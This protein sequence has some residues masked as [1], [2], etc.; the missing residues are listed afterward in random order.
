MAQVVT[1]EN[2]ESIVSGPAAMV[3]FWAEWCAPCRRIAPF[4]EEL[5]E[6][7]AGKVTVA[8]CDIEEV[9]DLAETFQIMSIPTLLFFK[10]G[11]LVDKIVGAAS[12]EDIKAKMAA[13]L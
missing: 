1:R 11:T 5:A 8:K 13:L 9:D 6:E 3:D 2:F 4:V 10:N 7:F 12:K